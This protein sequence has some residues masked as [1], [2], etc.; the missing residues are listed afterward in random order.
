MTKTDLL[1]V[2]L[3]K[4]RI[5][6]GTV[7]DPS[8]QF[9]VVIACPALFLETLPNELRF[10]A[11]S[12]LVTGDVA[13]FNTL[14]A[15]SIRG[16]AQ[17][18]GA[19]FKPPVP[20]PELTGLEAQIRFG[21]REVAIEPFRFALDSVPVVLR[22]RFTSTPETFGFTLTPVEDATE[23]VG[24]PHRGANLSAVRM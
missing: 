9:S 12:G 7:I 4:D 5:D 16:T 8:D 3:G 19:R 10:G 1:P 2:Q 23:L 22:G 6:T 24:L 11:E 20:W 18:L 21:N 14:K 13:F 15:P 17:I